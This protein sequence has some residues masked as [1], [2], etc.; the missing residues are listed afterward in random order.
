MLFVA[1]LVTYVPGLVLMVALGV[2]RAVLLVA[3]APAASVG[4]AGATGVGTA[5]A[6]LRYGPV[7]L[8]ALTLLLASIGVARAVRSRRRARPSRQRRGS[9]AVPV[10]G[11]LLVLVGAGVGVGTWLAGL[12]ELSTIPQEHDMVI[13]AVQAA[14][15]E[16]SG[17][18]A[19]WELL[20]ADVL[21]GAPVAFYPSGIH[22]LIAVTAA[23]T[24]G[25]VQAI[26]AITVVVLAVVLAVSA[27]ALTAVAARQLRLS[28][29]TATLAAGVAALVAV[30]L[31]RPTFHLMHDGGILA[32]AAALA[33]A[34]GVVAGVLL[35]P[36]LPRWSAVAVGVGCAGL[37]WVHPTAVVSVGVT[38]LAWWVGQ[39]LAP[40]GRRQLRGLTGPLLVA[41][42]SAGLLVAAA[43]APLLASAGRTTGFPP[44]SG[45]H[46]LREALGSTL[47]LTYGGYFDP[48]QSRAQA[49]AAALT[50]LG[51]VA[52]LAL[53][54]GYGPVAAWAVWSLVTI[55]AFHSPAAGLDSV[56]T[57]FFYHAL[58]RT[59][60][61]VSLLVPVLAGLG[62]VLT[63]N[64]VAVLVRRHTPLRARPTAAVLVLLAWVG[65]LLGQAP[66]Y[67]AI[68]ATALASRYSAPHFV[69]VDAEDQ[70]AIDWLA[71]RVR[72]GQR[73]LNSPNDGSTYLYVEQ[74]VPV[75]NVFTLG[76]A[77]VPYSYRLLES[78]RSY[79]TD[80]SVRATLLDLQVAWVYV[81]AEAPRIGSR[82]SPQG[83]AGTSG[84]SLASGLE[85]L[86]GLPGLHPEFRSG[87]VTVYSLDLD[88]L[89]SSTR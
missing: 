47:G 83:W 22:L 3:L 39:A 77:E 69:R 49:T 63:A 48:E 61:H 46:S 11:V 10:V 65:Y 42:A 45:P 18:A 66:E 1:L 55:G 56:I 74:G 86:E 16:R 51:V 57:G 20:P 84:F 8:G 59:W 72:P 64:L 5:L 36:R 27:A 25:T 70:R 80:P 75:V 33:M 50:A 68:N 2:R 29:S 81:D 73:V 41:G 43:L 62:I 26:N 85:D 76:V 13:H 31:Y 17:A 32:N 82:G 67:A 38:V 52:V 37:V 15:I 54:R 58:L 35:L 71:A 34:P 87:S 53:R 19:P 6:G 7:T 21:T 4:V 9:T 44:D 89:R 24:G 60:S 79:P 23:L 40:P 28:G 88:L 78:F 12:H 14:Y 30:G